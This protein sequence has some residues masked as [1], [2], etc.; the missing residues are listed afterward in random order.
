MSHD[1]RAQFAAL[2][3]SEMSFLK[4]P[5]F[6][7][8]YENMLRKRAAGVVN[9]AGGNAAGGNFDANQ[10]PIITPD[11]ASGSCH[12]GCSFADVGFTTNDAPFDGL[13]PTSSPYAA[14]SSPSS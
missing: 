5:Q 1:E 6:K 8:H 14:P 2:I 3:P 10:R 12:Y 4:N 13:A 7:H 11:D 9:A